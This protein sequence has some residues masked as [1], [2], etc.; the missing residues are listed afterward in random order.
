MAAITFPR[1]RADLVPPGTGPLQG[2]DTFMFPPMGGDTYEYD[3][4]NNRWLAQQTGGASVT[5]SQV[6]PAMASNGDLWWYCGANDEDP[7]LFTYVDDVNEVGS[8]IQSSPGIAFEGSSA[9]GGGGSGFVLDSEII[10]TSGT[11]TPVADATY[12]I[13]ALGGGGGGGYAGAQNSG[14]FADTYSRVTTGGGA[15]GCAIAQ[16]IALTTSDTFTITVGAGAVAVGGT[17]NQMFDGN[18]GG[19]TTVTGAGL[20]LVGGG[21][22]GGFA[23]GAGTVAEG[24]AGGTATGGTLNI[25]GGSSSG[26][27]AVRGSPSPQ[28]GGGAPLGFNAIDGTNTGASFPPNDFTVYSFFGSG[29]NAASGNTQYGGGG[30]GRVILRGGT[31]Q[32]G[33]AGGVLILRVL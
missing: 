31:G 12:S 2:G 18:A 11:W 14:H 10:A 33:G 29:G 28:T 15:G 19:D 4:A 24:G 5:V 9:G 23:G 6:P 7:S 22:G 17:D 32:T 26:G 3:V 20:E 16:N 30:Q 25:A 13:F 21:G 1:T 27:T 8:W